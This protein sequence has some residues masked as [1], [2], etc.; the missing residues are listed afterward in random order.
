MTDHAKD[1]LYL[2]AVQL[3]RMAREGKIHTPE[4][5]A[6][7]VMRLLSSAAHAIETAGGPHIAAPMPQVIPG[8]ELVAQPVE[9]RKD[10]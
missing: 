8:T 7:E 5:S 1:A 4:D 10:W 3:V 9:R 2:V 6:P